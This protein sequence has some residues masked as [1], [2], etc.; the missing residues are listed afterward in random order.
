[1]NKKELE[2]QKA[3][4]DDIY[5]FSNLVLNLAYSYTHSLTDSED[6]FQDVFVKYCKYFDRLKDDEHKE[7]WLKTATRH[8]TI[9]FLRIKNKTQHLEFNENNVAADVDE[10]LERV[11]ETSAAHIIKYLRK[12]YR[13][14]LDLY[15]CK[16]LCIKEIS[17]SLNLTEDAVKTRLKR[18]RNELREI[19]NKVGF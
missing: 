2:R 18:G 6:I 12:S 17:K 9:N 16:D 1:M 4:E 5:K 13:V 15:Y 7:Y 19:I 14:V 11:E 10:A 3:I 8:S